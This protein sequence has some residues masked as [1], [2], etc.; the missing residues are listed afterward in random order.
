MTATAAAQA[1]AAKALAIRHQAEAAASA[2]PP[3][4][5]AAERVAST[6]AQG[7]HGRRRVGQG[8]SFWQ[9]RQYQQGDPVQR[10]DWR[11]SAK[12]QHAFIR[13]NEWEAAQSVWLW[14]DGSASMMYRSRRD[15]PEKRE[16]AELLTLA[17]MALLV[18]G[19]ERIALLGLP[20]RP[21]TG[22]GALTRLADALMAGGA[23]EPKSLPVFELLPRFAHVVLIGDFLQPVEELN[24]LV[25]RFAGRGIGGY[26][27]QVLDPAETALPFKG[28]ARFEGLEGE[29]ERPLIGRVESVRG[30]YRDRL[31]RQRLGL[32]AIAR[33]AGWSY[34]RHSTDRPPQT[35][36]LTMFQALTRQARR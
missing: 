3:L 19:G 33:A 8:D 25:G 32:A 22:R 7:V 13:E 6:V 16:R 21:Q 28:R 17:L 9:F 36:L 15:L 29:A 20:V 24:A 31:E 1:Q 10:I 5:V 12:R 34:A 27:L 30:E 4:M 35:A 2:L 11:Q 18:R 26:I 14:R 23:A